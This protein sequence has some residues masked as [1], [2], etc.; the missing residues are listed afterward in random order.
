MS[1]RRIKVT[2][3]PDRKTHRY[4]PGESGR[5]SVVYGPQ[6]GRPSQDRVR[7]QLRAKADRERV[8][9]SL[10]AIRPLREALDERGPQ[11]NIQDQRSLKNE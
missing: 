9:A 11:R 1:E 4:G 8:L 3:G 7:D 2:G 6:R 10:D 5:H